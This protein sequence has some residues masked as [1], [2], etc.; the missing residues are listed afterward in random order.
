MVSQVKASHWASLAVCY[1]TIRWHRKRER[2]PLILS[3]LQAM[4]WEQDGRVLSRLAG[5]SR[6]CVKDLWQL[7]C[8]QS[9]VHLQTATDNSSHLFQL[10]YIFVIVC[11]SE[12]WFIVQVGLNCHITVTCTLLG[13]TAV[14]AAARLAF[15]LV[16]R[17]SRKWVHAHGALARGWGCFPGPLHTI[18]SL[19]RPL[20]SGRP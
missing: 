1:V 3:Q 19:P 10:P 20:L 12:I 4:V 7:P 14:L 9:C 8:P 13:S 2:C 16:L 5:G 17:P 15:C 11:I 18:S 6:L